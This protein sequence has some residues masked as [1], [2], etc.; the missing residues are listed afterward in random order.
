MFWDFRR[1]LGHDTIN[2][3]A[4]YLNSGSFF[5]SQTTPLYFDREDVKKA[6]HAPTN[7]TWVEC[8]D[9][10]VFPNGDPSP[11]PVFT[12]LPSVI[13]KNVRT[14]IIHGLADFFFIAEG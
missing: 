2:F 11:S 13:E 8:S 10:K 14:V 6:I 4:D 7:V 3:F 9:V 1:I 12:V 5:Q